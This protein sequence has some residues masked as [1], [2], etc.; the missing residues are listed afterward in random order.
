MSV[1]INIVVFIL[2]IILS[3]QLVAALMGL[4]DMAYAWPRA[5]PRILRGIVL[6]SAVI[7]L[8]AWA[9]G[10]RYRLAFLVGVAVYFPLYYGA[11]LGG[12]AIIRRNLRMVDQED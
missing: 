7:A 2:G 5:W 8:L 10:P 3:V 12:K 11:F 6:W 4:V 1:V 9:F